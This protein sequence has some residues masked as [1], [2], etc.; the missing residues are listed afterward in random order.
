MA[1]LAGAQEGA[2][3][4]EAVVELSAGTVN[5]FGHDL[6]A[7]VQGDLDAQA[8]VGKI[9]PGSPSTRIGCLRGIS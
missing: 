8:G 9:D 3:V 5:E 1:N 4:Q 6:T 7:L 2:A